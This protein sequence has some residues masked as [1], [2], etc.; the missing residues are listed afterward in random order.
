MKLFTSFL[1]LLFILLCAGCRSSR[2]SSSHTTTESDELFQSRHDS[3]NFTEKFARYLQE[4][5]SNLAIRVVKYYKPTLGDTAA[6]G[7]IESVTDLGFTSKSN[8]DSA[9]NEKSLTATSDTTS[10]QSKKKEE[11]K[12]TLDITPVPWYEPFIPYAALAFLFTFIL[13]TE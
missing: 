8:S 5:E 10:N 1:I 12:T 3:T 13:C 2:T 6:H 4:Q 9:I 11:V 7:A